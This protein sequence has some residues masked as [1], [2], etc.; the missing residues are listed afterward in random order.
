MLGCHS[1]IQTR[2]FERDFTESCETNEDRSRA[3]YERQHRSLTS[4]V[5]RQ[6]DMVLNEPRRCP[7]QPLRS[8]GHTGPH[9]SSPDGELL[10]F[11]PTIPWVLRPM[12]ENEIFTR[13]PFRPAS[14]G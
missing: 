2:Q 7:E 4:D 9:L 14:R 6:R 1:Q 5:Q 8:G 12:G 13:R 3:P 11:I 10:R